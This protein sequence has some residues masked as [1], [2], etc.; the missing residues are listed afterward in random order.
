MFSIV[1][2]TLLLHTEDIQSASSIKKTVLIVVFDLFLGHIHEMNIQQTPNLVPIFQAMAYW[3]VS[4]KA[5]FHH[6]A[7]ILIYRFNY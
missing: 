6:A 5:V 2:S 7:V 3:S 1:G 4:R